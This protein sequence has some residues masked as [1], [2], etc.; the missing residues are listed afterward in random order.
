MRTKSRETGAYYEEN[1]DSQPPKTQTPHDPATLPKRPNLRLSGETHPSRLKF[2]IYPGTYPPFKRLYNINVL[3]PPTVIFLG[4]VGVYFSLLQL[5]C[6]CFTGDRGS[7]RGSLGGGELLQLQSG[8]NE[9]IVS[10][11]GFR[12]RHLT[13][14]ARYTHFA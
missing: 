6:C 3:P 10:G 8:N 11:S 13:R 14:A 2:S 12:D 9:R 5:T 1:L 4:W 7:R